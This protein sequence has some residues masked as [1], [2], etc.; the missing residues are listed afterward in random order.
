MSRH[1]GDAAPQPS[2]RTAASL[3][4]LF[5]ELLFLLSGRCSGE[6]IQYQPNLL[7]GED[8]EQVVIGWKHGGHRFV[9]PQIL[10]LPRR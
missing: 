4:V 8:K 3:G 5:E 9:R 2:P 1:L 7:S 10:T 6:L